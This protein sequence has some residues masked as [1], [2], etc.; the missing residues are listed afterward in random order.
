MSSTSVQLAGRHGGWRCLREA[1][2]AAA[3]IDEILLRYDEPHRVYHDRRH[4]RRMLDDARRLSLTLSAAQ[5]LAI[6][7]HDAVHVP[8]A[9]HG[10]NEALSAQMLRVYGG[11]LEPATVEVAA[12]IVIDTAQH[13]PS[14]EPAAPVLDLDL[15]PLAAPGRSFDALSRSVFAELR[16]LSSAVDDAEAWRLFVRQRR[17]FF[18]RLLARDRIYSTGA[19]AERYE[20]AARANLRAAVAA[21]RTG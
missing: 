11:G 18:E 1:G 15:L 20:A 16:P 13:L 9:A 3:Q 21:Q 14:S 10:A 6:L 19:I 12:S 5:L 4:L 7:F 17:R 2:F 8:G